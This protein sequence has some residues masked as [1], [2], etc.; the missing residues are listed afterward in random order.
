MWRSSYAAG[1]QLASEALSGASDAKRRCSTP[2]HRASGR[3]CF[4]FGNPGQTAGIAPRNLALLRRVRLCAAERGAAER[5]QCRGLR[6]LRFARAQRR[7]GLCSRVSQLQGFPPCHFPQNWLERRLL[8]G[9][10]Q[11]LLRRSV[12]RGTKTAAR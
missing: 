9:E 8:R 10:M 11:E 7:G 4:Q 12:F 1:V 5:E 6:P 3:H 2:L